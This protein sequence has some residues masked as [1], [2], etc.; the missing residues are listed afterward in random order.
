ML[1]AAGDGIGDAHI[2][3]SGVHKGFR[4]LHSRDGE[5]LRAA[6]ALPSGQRH[7][8][9]CLD[10]GAERHVVRVGRLLHDREVTLQAR[11]LDE[12]DGCGE[13]GGLHV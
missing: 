10:V 1:V 2:L 6:L 12:E 5:S 8:F 9:M 13:V 11:L 4:L 3:K 7:G